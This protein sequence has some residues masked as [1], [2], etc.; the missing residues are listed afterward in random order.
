MDSVNDGCIL[1]KKS[2]KGKQRYRDAAKPLSIQGVMRWRDSEGMPLPM[3]LTRRAEVPDSRPPEK[4]LDF[5]TCLVGFLA[6]RLQ[7]CFF[8]AV[9]ENMISGL[10]GGHEVGASGLR[11]RRTGSSVLNP[12]K[13]Q[14]NRF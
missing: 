11:C 2:L 12:V 10:S 9:F 3:G 8:G 13:I 14:P 6:A 1:V 5:S 7:L 4:R